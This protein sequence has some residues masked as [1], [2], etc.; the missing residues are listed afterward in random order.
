MSNRKLSTEENDLF[1]KAT[2]GES[3]RFLIFSDLDSQARYAC[4]VLIVT[5]KKIHIFS[6]EQSRI[7][8]TVPISDLKEVQV[9]RMYG[10]ALLQIVLKDGTKKR[11]LR[12]TYALTSLCEAAVSYLQ[13]ANT[14]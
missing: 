10:N 7:T 12:F 6:K 13:S 11:I 1:C 2:P 4:D 9:K 5:D 8:E 14:I 3:I